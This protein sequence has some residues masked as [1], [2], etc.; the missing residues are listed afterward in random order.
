MAET[1][2][3]DDG[4]SVVIDEAAG[5]AKT[6]LNY[7]QRKVKEFQQAVDA[8]DT[9]AYGLRMLLDTNISDD[10]RLPILQQLGEL[11]AK[12]SELRTA[13]ETVNAASALAN[14]VGITLPKVNIQTLGALPLVPIAVG[15]AIAGALYLIANLVT[16]ITDWI[17]RS[18]VVA[19]TIA[20]AADLPP[21]QRARVL[22]A[23]QATET[24]QAQATTGLGSIA[25]IV[26]YV[27]FAA[28]AYF[29]YQAFMKTR[30]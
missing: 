28:V 3:F 8:V 13:A 26:Q 25:K 20:A 17:R 14:Q 6:D 30:S 24:A 10:D 21:E 9:A 29:A 23:I 1:T 15:A 7:Y 18:N 19:Q 5:T 16:W 11:E 2:F 27:A 4:G 22:E 12:K